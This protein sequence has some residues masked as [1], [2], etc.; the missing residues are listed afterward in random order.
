MK[1]IKKSRILFLFVA[2][3]L[4]AFTVACSNDEDAGG[5]ADSDG[6]DSGSSEGGISGD[7]ELQYFVGGYGDSW[8]KEVIAGFKE[9][10]PDVNVI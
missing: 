3:L 2:M 9:E 1:G 4:I 5:E 8:W 6:N 7:L 10:Y